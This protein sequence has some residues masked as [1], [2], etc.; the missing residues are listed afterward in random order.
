MASVTPALLAALAEGATAITPNRRLAR[1]LLREFDQAQRTAG[2][3][4]WPTP[5]ILPYPTWLETLWGHI[6][7]AGHN[8][9]AALL[10]APWQS[11]HLWRRIVDASPVALLDPYGAAALAA[12]AWSTVHGWGA[13][14]ESW[15]GWRRDADA[16]DDPAI[17]AAWAEAYHGALH[18]IDA[19]DIAQLPE[20]LGANAHVTDAGQL[21][22]LLVGFVELTPQQQRL[23]AALQAAGADIR[24]LDS[25]PKRPNIASRTTAATPREELLAALAWAREQAL[26]HAGATIGIVI[27]SLAERRDEVIALAEDVLCPELVLP[28]HASSRRPFEV[29]LG[30]ALAEVPLVSA[31]LDLITLGEAWLAAGRAAMLLRS[32]YLPGAEDAWARRA[33]AERG[34]IDDGRR[35]VTLADAITALEHWSPDLANRW[36]QAV[37]VLRTEHG[38]SPREWVDAWRSW[39][40][41]AGWPGTRALDSAEHQARKAWEELLANFLRLGSI[42]PHF[43]RAAAVQTLRSLARERI[44]Q[45]EGSFAPIQL[46]GVLEGSGLGF[47][48]LW[49]AGLSADRWPQAPSP[50]PLLP[51]EWQRARNMPRASAAGELAYARALT[52]RFAR[53]APTVVFSS[54]NCADDHPLSPSTLLLDYPLRALDSRAPSW[55]SSIACASQLESATDDFAPS[56]AL[57]ATAPG[58]SGIVT[59]QSDCPFQ[60]VA[61]HRLDAKPWPVAEAGF[62]ATERGLLVHDMMAAFWLSVRDRT[63]LAGLDHI[64]LAAHIATAAG[65]ALAE[66]R[67]ARWRNL[68]AIVRD[69]EGRRLAVLLRAWIAV[70]LERPPFAVHSV[71]SKTALAIGELTFR[72]RL[73]RL[74]TL[75]D[76]GFAIIDYKSGR[77]DKPG[78]WFDPRPRSAQLG[79]YALAQRAAGPASPIRA[80]AYAQLRADDIAAVGLAADS[81]AWPGLAE[82]TALPRFADW[83]A[84]ERRWG[85]S[86]AGLAKEIATGVATVTPRAQPSP[87]RNCGRQPLCRI[88]SVRVADDADDGDDDA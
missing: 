58:G 86:L 35:E 12:D 77:A 20:A 44:F 10:L 18:R 4:T 13:G 72:L 16:S 59:A 17:F 30:I 79:M 74:D 48:A 82:V 43:G 38:A 54:A 41:A 23:I 9:A 80:V 78:R 34:W 60:A 51:L 11:A 85:E 27:E 81:E 69:A 65:K 29:S 64:A 71:E 14:G 2:R 42:A 6:A 24:S 25:L 70:E 3:H 26:A 56:L 66:V 73:D 49:V 53:A 87:C 75:A 8:S 28:V 19:L 63:A 61:R 5:S 39:L 7:E 83:A 32:P 31:A 15:R 37:A 45:P 36:Q 62:S 67:P 33:A 21:R 47:D 88:E 50:N 46:L 40:D 52:A 76:G 22:A 57:G 1:Y 84:L 55:A 68:P